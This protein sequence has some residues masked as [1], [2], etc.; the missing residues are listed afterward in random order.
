LSLSGTTLTLDLESLPSAAAAFDVEGVLQLGAGLSLAAATLA[1]ANAATDSD[2]HLSSLDGSSA[3]Q[4]GFAF[5]SIDATTPRSLTLQLELDSTATHDQ[6]LTASAVATWASLPLSCGSPDRV[7]LGAV[8]QF[9][10]FSVA[11]DRSSGDLYKCHERN[12]G[13]N[14]ARTVAV[15]W[16]PAGSAWKPLPAVAKN[17]LRLL[18][19]AD[20]VLVG[21]V[22]GANATAD[23]Y[24]LTGATGLLRKSVD[25]GETWTALG[26]Q[27][28]ADLAA[29]AAS[30][31]E[32]GTADSDGRRFTVTDQG[33]T[34]KREEDDMACFAPWECGCN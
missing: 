29:L 10:Q 27:S 5:G 28:D 20:G 34:L 19:A 3:T 1:A 7:L 26:A 21:V 6:P 32:T 22:P 14:C 23:G 33:V 16:C 24:K 8:S 11:Y 13:S 17:H 31:V 15:E 9:P 25:R 4:F 18:G 2:F 30:L 12:M